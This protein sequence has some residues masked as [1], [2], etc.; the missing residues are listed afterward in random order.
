MQI[1]TGIE[2][3]T[4]ENEFKEKVIINLNTGDVKLLKQWEEKAKELDSI[5]KDN[6]SDYEKLMNAVL[7]L[8]ESTFGKS[9][10]KKINRLCRNNVVAI[11]KIMYEISDV[12]NKAMTDAEREFK[13]KVK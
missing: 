3:L 4:F 1:K 9:K 13:S 8:M 7:E 5:R 11:L 12:I 6:L 10:A 2:K